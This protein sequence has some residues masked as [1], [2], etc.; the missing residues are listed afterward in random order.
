MPELPEGPVTIM[1]TDI[2]GSTALRTSVGDRGADELFRQHDAL[3]REQIA[4][5]NGVDQG[6]AL[7]DGF[8]AVFLSTRRALACAIGIQKALDAFNRSRSGLPLNV[9]I[10]LNTGEVAW[11]DGQLSGEAVHAAARVCSA[12]SGGQ[13]LVSDVTRQLAG[14]VP[15]LTFRDAGEFQLKGFPQPWHLWEVVWVRETSALAEQVFVGREAELGVL[16]SRLVEALDGRGGLV[17]VGG[18]PGVGK[19]TLVRQLIQEAEQRGALAVFGRCYESEGTV[20]YSPFVEMLEQ[21]LDLMPAE[22]IREDMGE[23]APEVARLVPALRRRFPDIAPPLDLPPEQQQRYF[24][25]AVGSFVSRGSQ[26]FPLVMVMD[27]VHWADES[28]LRLIE[29]MAVLMPDLRVLGVGTYRDV[30]LDV[31]RPLAVTIERLLRDRLVERIPVRRFDRSTVAT[32]I[33]GLAGKPPPEVVVEAIFSETEGNPFFVEEVFRHLA[34]S[35]SLF[36][37]EEFRSDIEVDELDVPESVRLVVGRRLERL[38]EDARK[39]LAA[40]AV[41]GRGFPF[42][43]LEEIVDA[44]TD[45]LIDVVEAAEAARVIVAEERGGEVHYSFGHELI[46]QTLLS[47]LSVLRRQ[48]IHLAVADAIERTDR[49][50]RTDRP[51][52]IAHHLLAAGSAADA[53]RTLE[54]LELTAHRALEAAAFDEALRAVDD[55]LT[56]LDDDDPVRWAGLAQLRAD[57]LRAVGRFDDCIATLGEVIDTC[58]DRGLTEEAAALCAE[59]GYLQIWLNRFVEAFGTYTRGLTIVGDQRTASRSQLLALHG[60]MIGLSGLYED[61]ARLLDEAEDI[62]RS[63]GDDRAL[64]R[65]LWG[66]AMSAWS[67]G[68][69]REAIVYGREAIEVLRTTTDHWSLV[70][71]LAWTSFPLLLSGRREEVEEGRRCATEG[72][73]LGRRLGH[74]GGELLCLRGSG[75]GSVLGAGLDALERAVEQDLEGFASV[76]SPWV[77][78]SHAFMAA[79]SLFRGDLDAALD[80]ARL[81][82]ELE[83]MSAWS[84]VGWAFE[85]LVHAWRDDTERCRQL[86][87]EGCA[88]LPSGRPPIGQML[89]VMAMVQAS[90]VIRQPEVA[91]ALYPVVVDWVDDLPMSGFDLALTDRVAGMAAAAAMRWDDAVRH[92]ERALQ[93]AEEVEDT[94]DHPQVEHWYGEMLLE[95]GEAGDRQHAHELLSSA[96]ERYHALGMPLFESRAQQALDRAASQG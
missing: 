87:D 95:R 49:R 60:A 96:V 79:L 80:R 51:S 16:R 21:A 57:A 35:G 75:M 94:V 1:F 39:I 45:H 56:V 4:A 19:T 64:G 25:N 8:L 88:R 34:E 29:H 71:A 72:S 20:P 90:V 83:P 28:T 43:L 32:M 50:A 91:A 73:E 85:V 84:G 15:D 65:V 18:E 23:D 9:R 14:T 48:R 38:G 44:D 58:A 54:L 53:D 6:A 55:A 82:T 47:G 52:E 66:R 10:G 46:R 59:V 22:I 63:M 74:R 76:E 26:R 33:E 78:Q 42:G 40:G 31:S 36:D 62:A 81:A 24:F 61:G 69:P 70:D 37:G 41:V 86:L 3:V 2:E 17:L 7:G 11:A 67:N 5:H 68:W 12:G 30:E 27:D 93:R 89:A 77:S 92:F 13:I